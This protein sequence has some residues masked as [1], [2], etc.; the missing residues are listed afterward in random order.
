[1]SELQHDSVFPCLGILVASAALAWTAEIVP[2]SRRRASPGMLL[3]VTTAVLGA[4]FAILFLDEVS[5]SFV[6]PGV[7]CL[8]A[9]LLTAAPAALAGWWLVRRG[10]AVNPTGAAIA[11]G[12]LAGLAGVAMLALHCDNFQT[13]HVLVW[14]TAVVPVSAALAALAAKLVQIRRARAHSR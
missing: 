14:H 7:A 4:L 12:T 3:A 13:W 8:K 9:G 5:G 11:A 10:F 2:G 6:S 1:M